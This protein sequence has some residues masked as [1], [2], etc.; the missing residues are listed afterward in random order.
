MEQDHDKSEKYQCW[1]CGKPLIKDMMFMTEHRLNEN[2]EEE[3]VRFHRYCYFSRFLEWKEE[4]DYYDLSNSWKKPE[5]AKK[6]RRK[7]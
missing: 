4:H 5:Y 3:L 6:E 2:D 1:K 7:N